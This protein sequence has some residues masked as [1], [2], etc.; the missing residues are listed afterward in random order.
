[1]SA[2]IFQL[3]CVATLMFS[4][5]MTATEPLHELKSRK[6][7]KQTTRT[8]AAVPG[9]RRHGQKKLVKR[10]TRGTAKTATAPPLS[11]FDQVLFDRYIAGRQFKTS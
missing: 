11:A 5:L 9:R 4:G 6:D 1:M 10:S 2:E 8:T 3:L 7:K